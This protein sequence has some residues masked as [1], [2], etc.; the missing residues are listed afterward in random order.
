LEEYMPNFKVVVSD[1]K[2]RK[3]YQKE[4]DQGQSGLI[5]KKIGEKVSG[6]NLGLSG[7]ELEITGGSDKEGFPMRR[8]VEGAVRKRILL[9]YPPG[10]HAKIQGQR[11]RKSVRGNT[12]SPDIS[13]INAKVVKAGPKT[14]DELIGTKPK[15]AEKAKEAKPE[16][17]KEEEAKPAEK[18]EE[19]PKEEAKPAE[20]E[21][22]EAEKAEE[23]MG[24]KPLEKAEEKAREEKK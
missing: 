5:G 14:L 1:P 8:D 4:A 18:K 7:Y 20:E 24:V 10:F 12:I 11:K 22:P 3:A 2:S 15:E 23:K 17:K 19:K 21:K 9:A 16:E 13:Q 6:N